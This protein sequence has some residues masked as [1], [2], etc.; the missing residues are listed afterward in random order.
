MAFCVIYKVHKKSL[1]VAF[2]DST[3]F[4]ISTEMNKEIL[5]IVIILTTV[6]HLKKQFNLD[7]HDDA[8]TFL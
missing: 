3:L 5:Q 7:I 6:I 4:L 1:N 8:L 2:L